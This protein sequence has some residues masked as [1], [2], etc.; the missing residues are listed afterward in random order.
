MPTSAL[1]ASSS[2]AIPSRWRRCRTSDGTGP[3]EPA[4]VLPRVAGGGPRARRLRRL[5][6][7]RR[8][9]VRRAVPRAA[10]RSR[11]DLPGERAG[12]EAALVSGP[13]ATTAGIPVLD[14]DDRKLAGVCAGSARHFGIDVRVVRIAFLILTIAGGIGVA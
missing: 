12:E 14:T 6:P 8:R 7:R 1:G 11:A 4:G 10:R 2:C 5:D 13:M 3:C 9:H